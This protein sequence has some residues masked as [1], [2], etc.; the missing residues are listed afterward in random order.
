MNH[1]ADTAATMTRPR[2]NEA[3]DGVSYRPSMRQDE[4][5]TPQARARGT[6]GLDAEGV[7]T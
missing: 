1:G 7:P 2:I 6:L 4:H 5:V 3:K